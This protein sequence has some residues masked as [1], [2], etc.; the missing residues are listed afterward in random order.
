[1]PASPL[2]EEVL[3]RLLPFLSP[4]HQLGHLGCGGEACNFQLYL[5]L[6]EGGGYVIVPR[7]VW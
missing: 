6:P 7:E 5:S 2:M 4:L 3:K 1:M